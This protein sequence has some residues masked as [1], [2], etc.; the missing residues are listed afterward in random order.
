MLRKLCDI[1]IP[2][3]LKKYK[4]DELGEACA[5]EFTNHKSPRDVRIYLAK[6]AALKRQIK[7]QQEAEQLYYKQQRLA[8]RPNISL[9]PAKKEPE[10]PVYIK[11]DID[12]STVD[13]NREPSQG[14]SSLV[15][16]PM[17]FSQQT[18]GGNERVHTM[19]DEEK[20]PPTTAGG[21]R[22][23]RYTMDDMRDEDPS[24]V[25]ATE[26]ESTEAATRNNLNLLGYSIN[27][28]DQKMQMT[29]RSGNDKPAAFQA[30]N[31]RA[32]NRT[33]VG[34]FKMKRFSQGH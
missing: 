12:Q 34:F 4:I 11:H 2:S 14:R 22:S 21:T 28:L 32:M 26:R 9:P 30:V 17:R 15:E 23:K 24:K 31:R 29:Q 19:S 5:E 16:T 6:C 20:S 1:D 7:R 3:P 13:N 33:D 8:R 25:A 18:A 27:Q 10:Q